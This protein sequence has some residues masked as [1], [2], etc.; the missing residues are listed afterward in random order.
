[1][2]LK[3]DPQIREI[4]QAENAIIFQEKRDQLRKEAHEA[5]SKIQT[6]NKQN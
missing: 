2:R 3:E 1:M 5:I 4:L 6:E